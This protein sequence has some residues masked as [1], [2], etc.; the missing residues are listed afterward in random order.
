MKSP[1]AVL[2]KLSDVADRQFFFNVPGTGKRNKPVPY[3]CFSF[4]GKYPRTGRRWYADHTL[5]STDLEEKAYKKLKQIDRF[6]DVNCVNISNLNA[7]T[8]RFSN[9]SEN[10]IV[11]TFKLLM[12]TQ[13]LTQIML[14]QISHNVNTSG[15][16]ATK[17]CDLSPQASCAV[18]IFKKDCKLFVTEFA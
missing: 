6:G 9:F 16:A 1:R 4:S 15:G 7:T 8:I 18:L 2:L 14:T 11:V 12:L 13:L 5:S 3:Y 10:L 17:I